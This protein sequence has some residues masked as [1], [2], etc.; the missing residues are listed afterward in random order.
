MGKNEL[1]LMCRKWG[2]V[3]KWRNSLVLTEWILT[4]GLCFGGFWWQ[5]FI[6]CLLTDDNEQ[7]FL[8]ILKHTKF[9]SFI[10]SLFTPPFALIVA[11]QHYRLSFIEKCYNLKCQATVHLSLYSDVLST[12]LG[13]FSY[14]FFLFIVM[15]TAVNRETIT[16][17]S[18]VVKSSS[19]V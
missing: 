16:R 6:F 11:L 2:Q 12:V 1:D 5:D 4:F 17:K 8:T 9:L 15:D 3:S 14:F 10:T 18:N 7:K 13:N 19:T